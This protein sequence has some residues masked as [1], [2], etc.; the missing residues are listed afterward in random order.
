MTNTAQAAQRWLDEIEKHVETCQQIMMDA[1]AKCQ[2]Y[3]TLINEAKAAAKNEGIGTK[4]L[5]A[6][7]LERKHLRNAAKVRD[8]LEDEDIVAELEMLRDQV[9]AVAGIEDL[10]SFAADQI[11]GEIEAKRGKKAADRAK[12]KSDVLD[13]LTGKSEDEFDRVGRENAAAVEAGIKPLH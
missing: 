1:A 5:S 7:I 11:E 6:L 4:A 3:K 13:D 2:P 8:K 12:A 10:F 9:K